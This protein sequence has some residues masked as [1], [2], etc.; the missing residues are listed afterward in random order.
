MAPT[1]T[2]ARLEA[3]SVDT[4][5]YLGS[6]DSV[7]VDVSTAGNGNTLNAAIDSMGDRLATA[8]SNGF[9]WIVPDLHGNV[10]AQCGISGSITDVFRYDAYGNIIGTSTIG[11]VPSPWRFGG[12]IL[13]STAGTDTYDFGARAYVPDLGTFTSLDSVSGSAQNPLTLNRYLYADANPATLVDPDGHRTCTYVSGS[14]ASCSSDEWDDFETPAPVAKT[15]AAATK[16]MPKTHNEWDDF[17]R[18]HNEWDDFQVG[19]NVWTPKYILPRAVQMQLKQCQADATL[20]SQSCVELTQE[21]VLRQTKP[22]DL[23]IIGA[24]LLGG[25]CIIATAGVCTAILVGA[26]TGA[27][28]STAIYG[29]TCATGVQQ[30]C[31]VNGLGETAL[32]G[33]VLGG[34]S[35]GMFSGGGVA[36]TIEED[37]SADTA[38]GA[39]GEDLTRAAQAAHDGLSGILLR[40]TVAAGRNVGGDLTYAANHPWLTDEVVSALRERGLDV[41]DAPAG[42]HAEQQLMDVGIRDIAISTRGGPCPA[43]QIAADDLGIG[44]GH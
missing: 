40:S 17:E 35:G 13:E 4:Y 29:A 7:I 32:T 5:K 12:R 41:L 30:N 24:A 22:D 11:S 21:G 39:A 28:I 20:A 2:A 25:A 34:I 42:V 10:A 1:D 26:G 15:P 18:D 16:K 37:V 6:T 27:T 33:G 36:A 38:N 9:A 8:A 44:I 14:D 3:R 43:C 19:N 23:P 31:S